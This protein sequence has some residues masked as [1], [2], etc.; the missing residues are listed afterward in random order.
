[1]QNEKTYE[2]FPV[3][4]PL[5]ATA[6]SVSI[7]VLG[8]YIFW[9]LGILFAAVYVFFCLWTEFRI[10]RKSCV[11]CYY[12]GKR[13]GLGRGKLCALLFGKGSVERFAEREISWKDIAPDFL[14]FLLPVA[15]GIVYLVRDFAWP[16][17]GLLAI[18]VFLSF[19]GTALI[20]GQLACRYC[21]QRKLGCPA[22]RLF[23]KTKR[24]GE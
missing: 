23:D 12:Y 10:I 2:N 16:V 21:R 5:L 15:G 4:M 17:V 14:V 24:T 8:V 19:G 9:Q 13:C 6:V 7:Y 18:L 1:M 11:D 3:W 22:E 20:R